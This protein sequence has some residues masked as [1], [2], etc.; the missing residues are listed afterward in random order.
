MKDQQ[1][2]DPELAWVVRWRETVEEPTEGEL[3]IGDCRSKY[4]WVN[5]EVFALEKGIL[6]S[7]GEEG[8]STA[9]CLLNYF[10]SLDTFPLKAVSR[11]PRRDPDLSHPRYHFFLCL[12]LT[13]THGWT[14]RLMCQ[15]NQF[16]YILVK[17]GPV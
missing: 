6:W 5:R 8:K 16:I 4:Y 14:P 10:D 3:F 17:T 9:L 15:G 11:F 2:L 1:Q 13:L 7:K 12:V